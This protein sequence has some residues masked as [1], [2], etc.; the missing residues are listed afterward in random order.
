MDRGA[1]LD[2]KRAGIV[3][4]A[5]T[6]AALGC[7]GTA[8]GDGGTPADCCPLGGLS[9][10]NVVRARGF[11][12]YEGRPVKA[13]FLESGVRMTSEASVRRGAF[14]FAFL[15]AT[16]I[17]SDEFSGNG[18]GA[19]FIDTDGDGVCNPAVDYLYAWTAFGAAGS[20]CA[21]VDLTPQSRS[22]A[23]GFSP[24]LIEAARIVCPAVSDCLTCGSDG[25]GGAIVSCLI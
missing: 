18:A 10:A 5:V 21:T 16:P 24:M 11:T 19:V 12:A 22:C 25:D 4:V 13:A 9:F 20:T 17:C 15:P 8:A 23:G 3:L 2:I 14:D 6:A 7:G 1:T